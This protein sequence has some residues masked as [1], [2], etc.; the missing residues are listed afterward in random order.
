[1]KKYL[2]GCRKI[3]TD[4]NLIINLEYYL[5]ESSYYEEGVAKTCYGVEITNKMKEY[6]ENDFI[7]KLTVSKEKIKY[8]IDKLIANAVTPT[9]MVCAVDELFC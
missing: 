4:D 3:T 2:E 8:I 7:E 1:M 5:I 6:I 9:S